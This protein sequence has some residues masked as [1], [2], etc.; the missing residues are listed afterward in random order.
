MLLSGHSVSTAG[1][2]W[3]KMQFHCI[4]HLQKQ[5]E[6]VEVNNNYLISLQSKTNKVLLP[7]FDVDGEVFLYVWV[8]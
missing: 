5:L 2:R 6:Q 1:R 7:H 4:H 8:D 3:A